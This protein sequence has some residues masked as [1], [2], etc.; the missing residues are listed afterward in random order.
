THAMRSFKAISFIDVLP[1]SEELKEITRADGLNF[2]TKFIDR[3]AMNASKQ[4]PLAPGRSTF[5]ARPH[6]CAFMFQFEKRRLML[7]SNHDSR[8]IFK[9]R[10][11]RFEP[12][13]ENRFRI[14]W[15]IN[16]KPA[17]V[18]VNH[19]VLTG[20]INQPVQPID[21]FGVSYKTHPQ[22]RIMH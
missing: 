1:T 19:P 15:P 8:V 17:L 13:Q 14:I 2:M 12:A 16:G 9:D 18:L 6:D 21:S 7:L 10:S 11:E 22:Q 4:P 5:Q 20:E 3:I